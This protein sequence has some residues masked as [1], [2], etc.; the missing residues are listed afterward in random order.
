MSRKP[1]AKLQ[2]QRKPA[3][4]KNAARRGPK[5]TKPRKEARAVVPA[6][7][8]PLPPLDEFVIAEAPPH[9]KPEAKTKPRPPARCAIIAS[10]FVLATS[11]AVRRQLKAKEGSIAVVVLVPDADWIEPFRSLFVSR[12]GGR[13][14]SVAVDAGNNTAAHKAKQAIGVAT[15][16]ARGRP[17]VGVAV[18]LD[19]LPSA[20]TRAADLTIRMVRPNSATIGRAIQMFTGEKP[21]AGIDHAIASGLDF[22]DLVAA[23]R[24]HSK[25]TEI[26]ARLQKAQAALCGPGTSER[27]PAL[28][29]A[30]EYGA[31]RIWGLSLARDISDFKAGRIAWEAVD[32]GAVLFSEPGLGKSLFARILAEACGVPLVAFSIADLFANGPGYLDSVIKQSRAMF[33]RAAALASPCSILFCD[34]LDALPNR[35]SMSP[36]GADW[37]TPVITDFLLCLDNAVSRQR[38]GIVVIGAT[39][40]IAGVDTALLRPGRLE[41]SIELTRPDHAG[42]LNVLR[43]HLD[44]SLTG[45]DLTEVGHVLAGSTPAE[46]MMVVRGARRI[47]RYAGRELALDDLLK[48]VSPAD[49]I[50]PAALMRISFHEA[51]HAVGSLAVPAGILQ[52]CIIGGAAGSAGRTIIK[53]ETDDL[54][55]RDAVERRAVVTL[56]GRAAEKLLLDGSIA[57]GSGGDADSDL[58]VVTQFIASLHASTGLGGT[59]VYLVSHED[60]LK[61]VRSDLKIR[62]RVERHMRKV[63]KRADDVVRKH[64][65]AII[66]V[67]EQLRIRRHLSGEEIRRIFEASPPSTPPA[68]TTR[69]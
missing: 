7:I 33:Q 23:F 65:D 15:D 62:S 1:P 58:A 46:V 10:A 52:R 39:N 63:Q 47:A 34:E 2:R 44:S 42:I 19:A 14:E 49:D 24:R 12:F 30:V 26:V 35:A 50:E 67:A 61:A 4:R 38:A 8:A 9:A 21:P 55:T 45:A 37:W 32:R 29:D 56:C 22:N 60:A 59:L 16:L 64:R 36:R 43:Y 28:E 27:L 40:N 11:G 41:R 6:P 18:H 5:T 69:H 3:A 51:A 66:A 20:L 31:A 57:L 25:P 13:W 17:V 48:S 53:S 54:T 68:R